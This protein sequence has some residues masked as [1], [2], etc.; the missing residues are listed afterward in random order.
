[1]GKKLKIAIYVLLSIIINL[2]FWNFIIERFIYLSEEAHLDNKIGRRGKSHKKI[3]FGL[4]G[5]SSIKLDSLGFNNNDYKIEKDE[6]KKR[7]LLLGDS[8]TEAYQVQ[9]EDN[10]CSILGNHLEDKYEVINLGISGAT[11]AYHLFASKYI[12][13]YLQPDLVFIQVDTLQDFLLDNFLQ[14]N[15]LYVEKNNSSF[16][17]KKNYDRNSK[18]VRIKNKLYSFS[19]I[20]G[21]FVIRLREFANTLCKKVDN[22]NQTVQL[23]YDFLQEYIDWELNEIKSNYTNLVV[24]DF[25]GLASIGNNRFIVHE[26][27]NNSKKLDSLVIN[28]LYKNDIKILSVDEEFN[29]YQEQHKIALLGFN[30]KII[31][32]GHLNE[33]GHKLVADIMMQYINNL[34][35]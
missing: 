23:D 22:E 24:L 10:Y 32:Y 34:N 1:M 5:F 9:R 14:S 19:G 7:I 20:T 11:M 30:N 33:Q 28:S 6:N 3:V 12:S 29:L 27:D 13:E 2:I 15:W 26:S 4:E 35:F 17:I 21:Y 8:F 25:S 31:G 18:S 16:T